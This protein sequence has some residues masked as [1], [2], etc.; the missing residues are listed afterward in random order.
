MQ[1]DTL[2]VRTTPAERA[3]LEILA[4]RRGVSMGAVIRELLRREAE[5]LDLITAK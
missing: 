1:M 4:A 5:A 3:T 2:A